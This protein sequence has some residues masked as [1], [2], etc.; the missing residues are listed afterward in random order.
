MALP[1]WQCP[2]MTSKSAIPSNESGINSSESGLELT[3][4][5][6][7]EV[8]QSRMREVSMAFYCVS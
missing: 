3:D 5:E 4:N 7:T 8:W 1:M 2:D 6:M